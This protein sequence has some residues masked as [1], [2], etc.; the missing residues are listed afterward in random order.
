MQIGTGGGIFKVV[1][2]MFTGESFFITT[3]LNTVDGV[4]RVAFA[5]PYPLERSSP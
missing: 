2:R 3:F 5:A 1:E 4:K